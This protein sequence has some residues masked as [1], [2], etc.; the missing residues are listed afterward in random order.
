MSK[1]IY[2]F[3]Q[4]NE[5]WSPIF[6]K[7]T[8]KKSK[9]NETKTTT[10]FAFVE[11]TCEVFTRNSKTHIFKYFYKSFFF[12]FIFFPAVFI[13][14]MLFREV[15]KLFFRDILALTLLQTKRTDHGNGL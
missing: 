14:Q 5:R 8:S 7:E 15:L 6:F 1:S 3:N 2:I 10:F 12:V 13:L 4:E 9:L 11:R